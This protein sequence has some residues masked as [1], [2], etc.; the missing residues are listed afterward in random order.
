MATALD[1]NSITTTIG[2]LSTFS[3]SSSSSTVLEQEQY[4]WGKRLKKVVE[5]SKRKHL[6][7]L[8]ALYI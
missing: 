5:E 1:F 3:K 7:I 6:W 8:Q 2:N 4:S